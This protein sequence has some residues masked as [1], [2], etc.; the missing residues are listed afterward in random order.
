MSLLSVR[1]L[2]LSFG[3]LTVVNGVSFDLEPAEILAVIGPNGAGKTS[4]F[5][6]VTGVYRPQ[7]GSVTVDGRPITGLPPSR[8]AGLG[9]ARTFQN[10]RL[11]PAMSAEDNVR[12]GLHRATRQALWDVLLHTP[13]YRR[14]ERE[15]LEQARH[16]LD[17]AGYEGDPGQPA[18][19]LPYGEQRRVELARAL[20]AGPR[21]LLL[22]EPAAG[23]NHAERSGLVRLIR[24]VRS[25]GV[26]VLMIEHD[27]GLVLELADRVAVLD[28]GRKIADGPPDEIRT[29]QAVIDAYLGDADAAA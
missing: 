15:S 10:L 1:D 17:V 29:D 25:T 16:W 22:D 13:R 18:G 21:V 7:R 24:E 28:R 4:A 6:C 9:L 12:A 2:R 20:A 11:F 27:M 26:A 8:I 23:L 3:G 14:S 19:T 5:N